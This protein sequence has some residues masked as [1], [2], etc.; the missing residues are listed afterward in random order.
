MLRLRR[1]LPAAR[2]QASDLQNNA[3]CC[4]SRRLPAPCLGS[5]HPPCWRTDAARVASP[6]LPAAAPCAAGN[7][8]ASF[9]AGPRLPARAQP[10]GTQNPAACLPA[11]TAPGRA[12]AGPADRHSSE[13]HTGS[14]ADGSGCSSQLR[15]LHSG[16]RAV[17][18]VH[19]ERQFW[20]G[21]RQHSIG[22]SAHLCSAW[23]GFAPHRLHCPEW[24]CITSS[25]RRMRN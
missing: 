2:V 5:V 16:A 1:A 23:P 15:A 21:E 19:V 4:A 25:L 13:I 3:R 20:A 24:V 9:G 11:D 22:H 10:R 12:G 14:S 8:S 17:C 7:S 6:A 18:S